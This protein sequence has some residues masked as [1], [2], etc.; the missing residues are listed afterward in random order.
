MLPLSDALGYTLAEDLASRLTLPPQAVSAMD[1][2]AVRGEDVIPALSVNAFAVSAAGHPWFGAI[3]EGQAV[4][5]F[6]GAALPDG[7]DTIIIQEDVDPVAEENGINI[8]VRNAEPVG[9]YIRPA[10]LDVTEGQIILRAGT[11]LSA[12]AIGL[13]SAAG[14]TEALVSLRPRIGVLSTGDELLTR[15]LF[16][17]Q[18]K[19]SAQRQLFERVYGG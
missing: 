2:Y 10:G 19:L 9:R 3:N 11:Q 7:A 6:T 16:R 12:R 17:V 14:L 15:A 4:R 8:T 5:V 1:G 13:A 18:A